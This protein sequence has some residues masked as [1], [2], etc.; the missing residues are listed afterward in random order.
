MGKTLVFSIIYI[1]FVITNNQKRY[2]MRAT[3][4]RTSEKLQKLTGRELTFDGND[5]TFLLSDFASSLKEYAERLNDSDVV[6]KG[7]TFKNHLF[8]SPEEIKVLSFS[9]NNTDLICYVLLYKTSMTPLF[10]SGMEE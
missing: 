4:A 9:D 3:M 2:I 1:I 7:S 5:N 10:V 8:T 6:A